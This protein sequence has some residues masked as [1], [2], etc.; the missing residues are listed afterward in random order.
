MLDQE[1][2]QKKKGGEKERDQEGLQ[3]TSIKAWKTFI[4][5]DKLR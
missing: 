1:V 2:A 3:F 5:D 4:R